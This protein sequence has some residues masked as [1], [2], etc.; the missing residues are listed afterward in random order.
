MNKYTP[1]FFV[2]LLALLGFAVGGMVAYKL[3][4]CVRFIPGGPP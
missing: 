1:L 2:T 3:F 4:Y